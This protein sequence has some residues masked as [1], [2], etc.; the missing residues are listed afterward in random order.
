M[1]VGEWAPWKVLVSSNQTV[2][3]GVIG[4]LGYF[5]YTRQNQPWD[6]RIVGSAVA[7]TLAL[8]GAEG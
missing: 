2:N 4:T 5:A 7:G 1:G 8:F 6:R 3:V